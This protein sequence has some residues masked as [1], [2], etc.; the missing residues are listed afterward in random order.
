M[1]RGDVMVVDFP[2]SDRTGSKIASG[3]PTRTVQR[4]DHPLR[5]A[6]GL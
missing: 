4:I 2:F 1:N 3:L 5:T 6:L